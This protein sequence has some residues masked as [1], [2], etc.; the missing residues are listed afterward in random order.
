MT[1]GGRDFCWDPYYNIKN[2]THPTYQ[3][4]PYL[5]NIVKKMN[6][7]SLL[8]SGFKSIVVDELEDMNFSSNASKYFGDFG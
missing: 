6:G 2:Q 7:Q 1:Y 8:E 4:H 3:V 5:W